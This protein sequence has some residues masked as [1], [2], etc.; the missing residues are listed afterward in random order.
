[1][2]ARNTTCQMTNEEKIMI[3]DLSQM[4]PVNHGNIPEEMKRERRWMTFKCVKKRRKNGRVEY[5]KEPRQGANPSLK[6]S[7]TNAETW[8][9]YETAKAAVLAG[10]VDGLGFALGAGWAGVDLDD[11]IRD[12]QLTPEASE[13]IESINS[14]TEISPS[15]SGVHII[16]RG[17]VPTGRRL[18]DVE[19]YGNGRYFTMTGQCEF[20]GGLSV[21]Q[22]RQAQLDE[23]VTNIESERSGTKPTS[24]NSLSNG[25]WPDPPP[26][27]P[28][29]TEAIIDLGH[30]CCRHFAELWRGET[31]NYGDDDSRADMALIG[32]LAWLCGPGQQRL[33]YDIAMQSGLRREKWV[34]HRTYLQR[35][36]DA[37]YRDRSP[38]DFYTWRR[39]PNSNITPLAAPG[40]G[41][42][43]SLDL[44]RQETLDDIG[45]AR[46]L[47]AEVC[48]HIKYVEAW[49]KFIYWD[50][51][52]WDLDDGACAIRA[53]QDLRDA[54]WAEY[55]AIPHEARTKAANQFILSCGNAKH[56]QNIVSLTKSQ[57][58]IR[59]SHTELDRHPYLLNVRNGTLDLQTGMLLPHDP[60]LLITQIAAVNFDPQAVSEEWTRFVSECME[61]NPELIRFLQNSAGIALSADVSSQCLWL[62]HG[63]GANGKSTYLGAYSNM[64]GDYAAAAPPN[65]LMMRK[66]DSHP[67]ELAMLYAKRLVTL[68]EC[69]GGQQFRESLVKSLTGG[70]QVAVRR[71]RED[72]WTLFPTWHLHIS[73]NDPPAINGTDHGMHRRLKIIPWNAK[74]EGVNRDE[75]LKERLESEEHRSA[76]LNWALAGFQD[77]QTNG[78]PQAQ[79]VMDATDTYVAEQDSF[80]NFLEECTTTGSDCAVWFEDLIAAFHRWLEAHAE[81]TRA[82]GRKRLGTE[83]KRRGFRSQRSV[84]GDQRGKTRYSGLRLTPSATTF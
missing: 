52:R 20:F 61:H 40:A 60:S 10:N 81:S 63:D 79:A 65:F 23:I 13:I 46:R 53:A 41:G 37:A 69:E 27:P 59:I 71:M 74:F 8:C 54:L 50:G 25:T 64:L 3:T 47:A 14:Y 33:V 72:Y 21:V 11:A 45:F 32:N 78:M 39:E 62:N 12:G 57:Q 7:S 51:R 43:G 73:C 31:H 36:I 83:L 49:K 6:A 82:W 34:K 58:P 4:L 77:Y 18:D 84:R 35:T 44:R 24:Q 75:K 17:D 26:P 2:S 56:I 16:A 15:G 80:G 42:A 38:D 30:R 70:D 1:M 22:H 48:S 68:I 28:A 19:I 67:T 29:S 66:N 9:D 76:I 55:A 5:T